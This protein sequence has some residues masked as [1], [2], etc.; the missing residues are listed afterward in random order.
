MSDPSTGSGQDKPTCPFCGKALHIW[1]HEFTFQPCCVTPECVMKWPYF[2]TEAEA[3]AAARRRA[4]VL[5]QEELEA[6]DLLMEQEQIDYKP[7]EAPYRAW[8]V[9]RAKIR[10][11][12]EGVT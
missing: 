2:G 11:L 10:E 7:N 12:S 6:I 9:L 8:E 1:R 4:P 3:E 5:T